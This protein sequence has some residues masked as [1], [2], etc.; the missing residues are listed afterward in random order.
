[1]KS[2]QQ[3]LDTNTENTIFQGRLTPPYFN[4]VALV[5][6][7]SETFSELTSHHVNRKCKG[8]YTGKPQKKFKSYRIRIL[9][10]FC[11]PFFQPYP[12]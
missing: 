3:G 5:E 9:S 6:K 8:K 10:H 2:H 11:L 7:V 4:C 12:Y 1:M